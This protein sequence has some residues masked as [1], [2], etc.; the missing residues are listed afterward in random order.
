MK[1]IGDDD[2]P[3]RVG[4]VVRAF[5][6]ASSGS[7]GVA[8]ACC[9]RCG[10]VSGCCRRCGV[11]SGCCRRCGVVSGCCRRCG[12][13]SG[14][15]RSERGCGACPA[16]FGVVEYVGAEI[17]GAA[18]LEEFVADAWVCEG[19]FAIVGA[20]GDEGESSV[21][22]SEEGLGVVSQQHDAVVLQQ[23]VGDAGAVG[24]GAAEGV[25]VSVV[26]DA[27][28]LAD[29]VRGEHGALGVRVLVEV[30]V[31]V[32]G[33]ALQGVVGELPFEE[34]AQEALDVGRRAEFPAARD[35][36][37]EPGRPV[38]A[39]SGSLAA[40]GLQL[41]GVE[42]VRDGDVVVVEGDVLALRKGRQVR[43]AAEGGEH[44]EPVRVA[45]A[46]RVD[47]GEKHVVGG[48]VARLEHPG[49]V[50]VAGAAVQVAEKLVVHVAAGASQVVDA[51]D[52]LAN[53]QLHVV[54]KYRHE[55][56]REPSVFD[57]GSLDRTVPMLLDEG[58]H[59]GRKCRQDFG[60]EIH[61]ASFSWGEPQT[62][63]LRWVKRNRLRRGEA[64]P[65]AMG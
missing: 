37:G 65:I 9:R 54:A 24:Q 21:G 22:V 29:V 41:L 38:G 64:Q 28:E 46:D 35:E 45:R 55:C 40:T 26:L 11:V 48:V 17:G 39:E 42:D 2:L 30:A 15:E 10:V 34:R 61:V 47:G 5:A 43:A 7:L 62:P 3:M 50:Q 18:E 31:E 49:Q 32:A 56:F 59:V 52:G 36:D 60:R 57:A 14:C 1:V 25:E 23:V 20:G 19:V 44:D 58:R 63:M 12:V 8:A 53:V 4:D 6:G 33:E 51:E 13:V 27:G 16:T